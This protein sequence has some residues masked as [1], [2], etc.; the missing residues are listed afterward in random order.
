[1]SA[2]PASHGGHWPAP[3]LASSVTANGWRNFARPV[4]ANALLSRGFVG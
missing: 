2:Q 4:R 1:M 3:V